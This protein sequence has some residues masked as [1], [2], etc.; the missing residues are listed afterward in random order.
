MFKAGGHGIFKHFFD[1][2][3]IFQPGLILQGLRFRPEEPI[4]EVMA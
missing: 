2:R 1:D 3:E 4:S